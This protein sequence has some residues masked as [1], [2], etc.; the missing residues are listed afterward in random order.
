MSTLS[1]RIRTSKKIMSLD[2][3]KYTINHLEMFI[4][5]CMHILTESIHGIIEIRPSE[6]KI[7]KGAN[8]LSM[9]HQC[10]KNQV[11]Q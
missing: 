4:G 7:L 3:A 11:E 8:N 9:Y 6:S 1:L 10:R 5:R 2:I